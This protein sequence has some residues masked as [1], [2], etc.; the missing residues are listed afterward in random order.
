MVYVI[1]YLY[2]MGRRGCVDSGVKG[3]DGD[4]LKD[5]EVWV[6]GLCV[7]EGQIFYGESMVFF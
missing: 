2:V 1:V 4:F 6:G 3:I 7:K 5:G